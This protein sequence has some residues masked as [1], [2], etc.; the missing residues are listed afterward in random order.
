MKE[1]FFKF[2]KRTIRIPLLGWKIMDIYETYS[3]DGR[4]VNITSLADSLLKEGIRD[5]QIVKMTI[6]EEA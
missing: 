5:C 2:R 1:F 6:L 3:L 4:K